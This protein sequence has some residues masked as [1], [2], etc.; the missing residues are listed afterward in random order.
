MKQ[1]LL[2]ALQP[3]MNIKI[4]MEI[5]SLALMTVSEC[6]SSSNFLASFTSLSLLPMALEEKYY[7]Q[8]SF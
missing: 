2:Q 7:C 1:R 3:A 6:C 4:G 5:S 8:S